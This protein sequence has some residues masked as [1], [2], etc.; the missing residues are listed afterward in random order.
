MTTDTVASVGTKS[1]LVLIEEDGNANNKVHSAGAGRK[2]VSLLTG[3]F[4]NN[5][6]FS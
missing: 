6:V 3:A 4:G 2:C 1:A 5:F